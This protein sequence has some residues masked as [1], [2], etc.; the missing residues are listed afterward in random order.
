LIE[1]KTLALLAIFGCLL[2]AAFAYENVYGDDLEP[3][4]SG[5]MAL[6]GWTRNG[7]C[8][9]N[10]DDSGSH[11]ICINLGSTTGGNFCK[12][13]GQ[14]DWCSSV[15]PCHEDPYAKCPVQNWC[16]CQWAFA[17]YIRNAGG[18]SKIQNVACQSINM[19]AVHAYKTTQGYED[20]LAC[21]SERCGLEVDSA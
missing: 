10:D 15:M 7:H 21:L 13:T 1:M 12:V 20:V 18:C 6:T 4:S 3:C 19:Q 2:S 5:G 17:S 16:V 8:V 9:D 14:S 11:H